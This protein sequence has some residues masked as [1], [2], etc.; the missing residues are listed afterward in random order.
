MD[1]PLLSVKISRIRPEVALP[2]YG[3]DGAVAF[4]L[5][6]AEDLTIAPKSIA[7]IPTGLI[8]ATP[9]GYALLLAPRSSLFKK[10]GL[11]LGNTVGVID[12]DYCGPNDEILIQAWNPGD[13]PVAVI[14]GERLVQGFFVPVPRVA[15]QEFT[16]SERSRGGFGSTNGYVSP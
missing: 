4:D 3:S 13:I 7:L 10:K 12:Q 5:A 14:K 1:A 11:R 2:V 16:P 15:W 8:I 6:S 9:A